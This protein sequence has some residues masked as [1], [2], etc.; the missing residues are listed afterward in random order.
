MMRV[1]KI[2]PLVC[3]IAA[4]LSAGNCTRGPSKG[5]RMETAG[6]TQA[7]PGPAAE[8]NRLQAG[9]AVRTLRF[10]GHDWRVKESSENRVGPGPNYFSADGKNVSVDA[11]GR[12]HLRITQRDEH[13]YCAEVVSAGSFGYGTYRFRI[14]STVDRLDP[15]VVAG[16]FT[17]SD[18]AQYHH[19]EID[20]EISRWGKADNENGQFVVQ[21]YQHPENIERFQIPRGL[22][23]V[24]YIF[25]WKPDS[26]SF[27]ARQ[28]AAGGTPI[29]QRTFTQGVP[30]PGGENVRINLWLFGGRA[31]AEGTDTEVVVSQFEFAPLTSP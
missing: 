19:R 14:E 12:L 26:V 30:R 8:G 21:P 20:V 15:S 7:S 28:G 11:Q 4:A 22:I 16:F 24:D 10:A 13:W 1:K 5:R 17:W 31:P 9:S 3:L 18:E 27:E 25:V 23:E 29:R 2:P 6:Q